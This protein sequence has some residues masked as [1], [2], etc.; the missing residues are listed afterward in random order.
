MLNGISADTLTRAR[1]GI[2]FNR[3]ENR[4]TSGWI[5]CVLTVGGC[6]GAAHKEN[7]EHE[8]DYAALSDTPFGVM[9]SHGPLG[10]LNPLN[11]LRT[12]CSAQD[13]SLSIAYVAC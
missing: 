1:R 5:G 12:P 11:H 6:G 4:V 10:V 2:G 8:G 7:G 3:H 9:S 13:V